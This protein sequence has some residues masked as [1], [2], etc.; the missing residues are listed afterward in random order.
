MP[1][2]SLDKKR[3]L[4]LV[5]KKISD[6]T[7]HKEIPFMGTDLE[8]ITK[9]KIEVEIFPD[10]PDLLSEEGFARYLSSFL[11]VKKGL[12][13]YKVKKSD[14]EVI[15]E[16]SVKKVRPFT[17]CAVAKNLSLDNK[18]LDSLI[19]MQ[20][21]LH[22]THGRRRKKVAIGVYPLDKIS[23]PIKYKALSPD[24][25]FFKPLDSDKKLS[26]K[27]IINK[28]DKGKEFKHLLKGFNK[29]PVF[30]DNKNNFLSMPPVINSEDVGKVNT[31]TK[32]VFIECSGTDLK[33][34]EQALNIVVTNLADTGAEIYEVKVSYEDKNLLTPNLKNK[35]LKVNIDWI[36]KWLGLSL[37]QKEF[38]ESI[39]KCGL[40]YEKGK[41]H[42]PP[43]RVDFL[44]PVDVAEDV[45][46]GYKY[47][48]FKGETVNLHTVGSEDK[49][50]ILKNKIREIIIGLGFIENYSLNLISG[51]LQKKLGSKKTVHLLNSISETHDTM[52][53][54][55]IYSLL[56]N[57]EFNKKNVYPQKMFEVGTRYVNEKNG[58]VEKESLACLMVG[59]FTVTNA[60][61]ILEVFKKSFGINLELVEKDHPLFI[62]GRS[63]YVLYKKKIVGFLGELKPEFIHELE[64]EFPICGLELDI[65]FLLEDF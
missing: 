19:E 25:I 4:E 43:Y 6:E 63:G 52:R 23:F 26:G 39:E 57:A 58:V 17:V 2:I 12:R 62:S 49:L 1:K 8:E 47:Y 11:G 60:L 45:A 33:A 13:N 56:I 40:N 30:I 53:E 20:E 24:K 34:L 7:L 44:H 5:G 38:K 37:N 51:D 46:K 10:R 41:V 14:Y 55:V 31:S 15:V 35:E 29:Y 54:H 32:E 64:I 48:N 9:E 36:N 59:D 21:K 16:N 18:K 22:I 65:G 3:V 27:E 28:T 42:I 50:E 61:Q